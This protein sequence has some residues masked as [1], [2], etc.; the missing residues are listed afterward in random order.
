MYYHFVTIKN[1]TFDFLDEISK[2]EFDSIQHYSKRI[3]SFVNDNLKIEPINKKYDDISSKYD[4]LS[5]GFNTFDIRDFNTDISNYL[6]LFKK[7]VDNWETRLSR[8]YGK[9]SFEFKSFKSAQSHVYDN[10]IEYRI[11]YRLRNF[12]QH[13]GDIITKAS[14][15]LDDN[16]N[17]VIKLSMDRDH[18][19]ESFSEWKPEEIEYLKGEDIQIDFMPMFKIFNSCLIEIHTK[20][21]RLYGTKQTFDSAFELLDISKKFNDKANLHVIRSNKKLS[22]LNTNNENNLNYDIYRLNLLVCK[23]LL[24]D[25]I[26][27]QSVRIIVVYFGSKP[28]KAINDIAIELDEENMLKIEQ[29]RHVVF[30]DRRLLNASTCISFDSNEKGY[31]Y[32]ILVNE[33][34]KLSLIDDVLQNIKKF[35]NVLIE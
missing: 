9:K 20:V 23:Q 2:K 25:Y 26:R 16:D 31:I 22:E 33:G 6:S 19:L 18:L 5:E 13:C 1:N 32:S 12:D 27:G 24:K 35:L 30:G 34:I 15:Y 8:E 3:N 17:K 21:L 10:Y 29:S 4:K 14:A 28:K 11:L 7:Y